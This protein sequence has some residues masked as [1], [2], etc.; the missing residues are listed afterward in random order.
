MK[1]GLSFVFGIILLSI[2]I[3]ALLYRLDII[4]ISW[5]YIWPLALLIP[6]VLFHLSFI[7]GSIRNAGIL[8]P[9]GILIIIAA[10]FYICGFVGWH[11]MSR[12]WP[13]FILAPAIGLLELYLFG[14]RKRGLLIPICLLAAL[15]LIFLF[16][17]S[18]N[19]DFG[20]IFPI[21]L[22]ILGLI[23]IVNKRK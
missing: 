17:M 2:G 6:G 10:I 3:L 7:V 16:V 14:S 22:I 20:L 18:L 12:L 9:G 21:I 4:A 23:I 13:F 19:V 5:K 15:G 8:V 1:K 11:L